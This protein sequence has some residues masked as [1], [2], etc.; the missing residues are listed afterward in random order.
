MLNKLTELMARYEMVSPGDRVICAV[1]GGADSMA[2]LW[3]MYLLRDK[4]Q[5]D[6][7]A[8][9]FNHHLRGAESDRDEGFVRKFCE[10]YSIPFY[11]GGAVVTPGP[12]GLE[13]A[14]REARYGF[15]QTLPG[16][17][18]TAHTADDNAETVLMHLVRG[19]GLKGLGGIAPVNGQMIRP[20]LTVTRR[21]V[22]EFL[23]EYHIPWITDSSNETDAFLRNRLRHHVM[24]LIKQEN[25]SF[26][27]N[28]TVMA[29]RLRQDEEALSQEPEY[30]VSVLRGMDP[31]RRSR[32]LA[33]ALE[34]WG[35]KEP[36]GAHIALAESLVFSEKPSARGQFPG[37]ITVCRNYDRLELAGSP[38]SVELTQLNVPGV[39]TLPG[40]NLRIVCT[41]TD[42]VINQPDRFT[43]TAGTELWVRSRQAGDEI[44]LP[45]G[46]KSLK[47]LFIDRKIPASSRE[48]VPVIADQDGILGVYSIGADLSRSGPGT[49]IRF[50]V[51]QD[52]Q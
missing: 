47:K 3:A 16:K 25:P 12:K 6:L 22:L 51:M 9:H 31:A 5:I 1:S 20:M 4:L 49:E 29:L 37:G 45:G 23:E 50:E 32:A 44:R 33:A 26:A 24:P 43:V 42:V 8:T 21:D 10:D 41:P 28:V 15:F 38:A 14:A 19:T 40:L 7:A 13:A 27:E 35:V 36:E 30:R 52:Q 39:T 48:Q 11:S 34:R 2:L 18:A 17:I 46:R